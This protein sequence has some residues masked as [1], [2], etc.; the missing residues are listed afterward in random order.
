[1]VGSQ[2]K[3][4]TRLHLHSPE[5]PMWCLPLQCL[6]GFLSRL[7]T[8]FGHGSAGLEPLI[9]LTCNILHRLRQVICIHLPWDEIYSIR[10]LWIL[11]VESNSLTTYTTYIHPFCKSGFITMVGSAS[12]LRGII[13]S[14]LL[15]FPL[16]WPRGRHGTPFPEIKIIQI[17][18]CSTSML[19][20]IV[21]YIFLQF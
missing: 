13:H 20:K 3:S 11:N 18:G 12:G 10:Y 15:H 19:Q 16:L 9:C 6:Y 14:V 21:L 2:H 4:C 1:M 17:G 7:G 5:L 8:I